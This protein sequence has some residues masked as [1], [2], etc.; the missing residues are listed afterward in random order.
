MEYHYPRNFFHSVRI[1][2][3]LTSFNGIGNHANGVSKNS[4]AAVVVDVKYSS[5]LGQTSKQTSK[6]DKRFGSK[7]SITN[8]IAYVKSGSP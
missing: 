5:T 6:E 7:V 8:M 1:S 2:L 3:H 4:L